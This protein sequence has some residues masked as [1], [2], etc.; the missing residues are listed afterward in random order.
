M[1]TI[2][3]WTPIALV[4]AIPAG[5]ASANEAQTVLKH[6]LS[7]TANVAGFVMPTRAQVDWAEALFARLL[8]DEAIHP[9]EQGFSA[10]GFA[11]QNIRTPASIT[12][13][14]EVPG[15]REGK[16]TYLVRHQPTDAPV[17]L[18]APHR[19]FDKGTGTI[20]LRLFE[21]APFAA[22]AWNDVPRRYTEDGRHVD[23]DLAR[24]DV[25]YLTAMSRAFGR[26]HQ[27]G[28]VVQLHGFEPRKRKPGAG[29]SA[30]IIISD[31]TRLPGALVRAVAECLRHAFPTEQVLLFPGDVDELG[32][33]T[34]RQGAALRAVG[35]PGFLHL[36]MS[37]A[38]RLILQRRPESREA[39]SNCLLAEVTP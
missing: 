3:P 27:Q 10:L 24:L 6:M 13:V 38:F 29:T 19:F 12:I 26:V 39:L 14:R 25:H 11:V 31:G 33:T 30:T 20:A 32:G 4:L 16:G 2:G 18:Q 5:L 1:R 22:L 28:R 7:E 9:I 23:A 21:E 8:L 35:S 34:N 17:M 36:E 15:K 37:A